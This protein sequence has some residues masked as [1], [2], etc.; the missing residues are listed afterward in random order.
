MA[1][2]F[3][4]PSHHGYPGVMREYGFQRYG[5]ERTIALR[6]AY[7]GDLDQAYVRG[8][9]F[10]EM[11]SDALKDRFEIEDIHMGPSDHHPI[12]FEVDIA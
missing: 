7:S 5:A 8:G 6:T 12:F 3:N 1:G 4:S 2:D 11:T 10:V 9:S